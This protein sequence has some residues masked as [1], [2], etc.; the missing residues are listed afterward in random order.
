MTTL[1]TRFEDTIRESMARSRV[2]GNTYGRSAFGETPFATE[3]GQL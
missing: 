3:M 1:T 2:A